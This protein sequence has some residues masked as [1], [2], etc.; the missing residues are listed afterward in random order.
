MNERN[1]SSNRVCIC[2]A[3]MREGDWFRREVNKSDEC[4]HAIPNSV[5]PGTFGPVFDAGVEEGKRQARHATPNHAAEA[6]YLLKEINRMR[7]VLQDA[8]LWDDFCRAYAAKYGV[9][10]G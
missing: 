2:G 6:D 1:A 4:S 3:P 10:R 8:D 9:F 5:Q 7:R